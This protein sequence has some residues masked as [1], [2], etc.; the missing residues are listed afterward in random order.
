MLIGTLIKRFFS[1]IKSET[2][3]GKCRVS[4]R[5][6]RPTA[7][8]EE[9]LHASSDNELKRK[10][11]QVDI[12]VPGRGAGRTNHHTER[13]CIAHL[14]ATIPAGR[15][16]FPLTLTHGD[17]PDFVLSMPTGEVGIEHTEAI[18]ENVA[19]AQFLRKNGLGP[20]IYFIPHARPGEPRKTAEQLRR[21]I[22]ADEP[23]DGWVGD[24]AE[25]EWGAAMVHHVKEKIAKANADGFA[26]HPANW[27]LVYDNWPLPHINITKAAGILHPLLREIDAFSTFDT[28]FVLDNS[29]LCEFRDSPIVYPLVDPERGS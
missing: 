26:R 29:H 9:I 7:P 27:L 12:S 14:L 18:P 5:S 28:I 13:Y 8:M 25:R 4:L 11:V 15:L 23:G 3:K 24:S 21:E 17:K 1:M 16:S 10:L 6:T 19:H 20:E 22:E 2:N